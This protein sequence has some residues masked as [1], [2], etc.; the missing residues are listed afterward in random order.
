MFAT[1][2]AHVCLWHVFQTVFT[3]GFRNN[4]VGSHLFSNLQLLISFSLTPR[5]QRE[6]GGGRGIIAINALSYCFCCSLI[7]H[8]SVITLLCYCCLR[9]VQQQQQHRVPS[10]PIHGC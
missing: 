7:F 4:V 3:Q 6:Q 9:V 10:Q 2:T 1:Q 8:L 5:V